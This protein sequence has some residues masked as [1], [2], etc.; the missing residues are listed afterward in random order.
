M[1]K[2]TFS[3]N[4]TIDGYAD[5][6]SGIA[7]DELHK[8][9]AD[10]LKDAGI[11]LLGRKTYE[12]M[13]SYWPHAREDPKSTKSEIEFADRYNG[14]EKVVFSKTLKSVNW[15][16]TTLSKRDLIDEVQKMKKQNGKSISAGSLSIA[17]ALMEKNLI[18]EYWFLVHPVI[19]GKGVHL[20]E[21]LN[22]RSNLSLIDTKV[23]GS[24]VVVLH[25]KNDK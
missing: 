20:F 7:D 12:M 6:T 5:H 25:Y 11:V 8:F 17:S 24:G 14:I 23:F 18:D 10:L 3:I 15:N 1:R 21:G 16:N 13:A 22:S 19:L 9:F 2:I 4:I